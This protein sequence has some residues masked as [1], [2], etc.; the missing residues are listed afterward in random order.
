MSRQ[1]LVAA[2]AHSLRPPELFTPIS[3]LVL[4]PDETAGVDCYVLEDA[5]S[6]ATSVG[7]DIRASGTSGGF[8]RNALL[9]FTLTS[10]ANKRLLRAR[11]VLCNVTSQASNASLPVYAIKA[12][13]SGWVEGATWQYAVP[14]SV[15]W[16]GDTGADAGADAGCSVAGTD[17]ETTAIGS[18]EY[19]ANTAANTP[20]AIELNLPQM[21]AMVAANY[22]FVI[23]KLTTGNF[24]LHS[25]NAASAALRP[26]LIV[27]YRD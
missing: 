11:L 23:R 20:H 22:G 17:Y 13:N 16:A 19:L 18:M 26:K 15:R 12:A 3:T 8:R 21:T 7:A 9:K 24:S 4:Q 6:T 27:N 25:S 14:S 2:L 10:L 1:W 5:P